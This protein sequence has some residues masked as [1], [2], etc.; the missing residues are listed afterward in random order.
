MTTKVRRLRPRQLASKTLSGCLSVDEVRRIHDRLAEDFAGTDDPIDPPGVRSDALLESAVG[1]Q[2]TGWGPIRKYPTAIANAATLAFGLCNDHPFHNGNK[3]TALVAMLA[4]LDR[5]RLT[6]VNTKQNDLFALILDLAQ[7][8]LS[9]RS[10]AARRRGAAPRPSPDEEVDALADWL[11][12]RTQTVVR[13]ERDMTFRQLRNVL[14][15]FDFDFDA[16]KG[17]HIEIVKL[18]PRRRGM[19]KRET[20]T[21]RKRIGSLPYPGESKLVGIKKL[22]QVRRM[23][24]LTEED[25]VDS[26]AFYEGADTVD[27]FINEYRTVLR[28]LA[29]R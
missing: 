24:R 25:G 6:L 26:M 29:R 13:G 14:H 4:H 21:E 10:I 2:E 7:G 19:I 1:R 22:K 17:N 9:L 8:Q 11:S 23:C 27:V 16:Q 5:N 28:R 20:V 12:R 15:R 3:R 18:V